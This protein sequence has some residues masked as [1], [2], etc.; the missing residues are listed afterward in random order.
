VTINTRDAEAFFLH[1]ELTPQ[2]LRIRPS[3]VFVR[4]RQATHKT[5]VADRS[6][7]L[8]VARLAVA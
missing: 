1:D 3:E 4:M 8:P 7:A 6:P 5:A 2:D